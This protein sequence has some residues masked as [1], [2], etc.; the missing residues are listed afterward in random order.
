MEPLC[1]TAINQSFFLFVFLDSVCCLRFFIPATVRLGTIYAY[2]G[3]PIAAC[4]QSL[5]RLVDCRNLLFGKHGENGNH[6][7][8]LQPAPAHRL[9]RTFIL[10]LHHCPL[11]QFTLTPIA[12]FILLFLALTFGSHSYISPCIEHTFYYIA[13]PV[14]C[15]CFLFPCFPSLLIQ[16][17]SALLLFPS[18]SVKNQL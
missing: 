3:F 11:N 6:P 5:Y 1:A 16:K 18:F 13:F 4:T 14:V 12:I 17:I 7:F 10:L 15:N 9:Y 8:Q 2:A